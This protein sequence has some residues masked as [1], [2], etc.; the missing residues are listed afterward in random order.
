[1][2]ETSIV[3]HTPIMSRQWECGVVRTAPKPP[4]L[5]WRYL[6]DEGLPVWLGETELPVEP[7]T[8][9]E[10][11]DGVHG[12]LLDRTEDKRMHLTWQPA[13]WNHDSVLQL[14][15]ARAHGGTAITFHHVGLETE[16]EHESMLAHWEI[17][18][19]HMVAALTN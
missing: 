5:V 7:G 6:I 9:Y 3:T 15:V 8:E 13:K 4:R 10:T 19:E 16:H 2:S 17:V 12:K 11:A 14:S 18:A 1:M